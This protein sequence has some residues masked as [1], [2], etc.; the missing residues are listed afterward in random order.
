VNYLKNLN[1]PNYLKSTAYILAVLLSTFSVIY[2]V[3]AANTTIGSNI[4]TTGTLTVGGVTA[5]SS[6]LT[7]SGASS[8]IATALGIAS[9]SP[10]GSLS[11]EMSINNP[12]F[13]VSNNGSSTPSFWVGGVNQN[14]RIGIGTS[15]P[16]NNFMVQ[17][18]AGDATTSIEIYTPVTGDSPRRAIFG[19]FGSGNPIRIGTQFSDSFGIITNDIERLSV[20]SDGLIGIASTSPWGLLSVEMDTTN[21]SFVVSNKNHQ[22]SVSVETPKLAIV[23]SRYFCYTPKK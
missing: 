23:Q 13:V 15:T 14:G 20:K 1:Y 10:W 2:F 19:T 21:P 4:T 9:T 17:G 16:P 18:N 8:S 5:L 22:N 6:T 12:S 7:V 3:Y 11:V